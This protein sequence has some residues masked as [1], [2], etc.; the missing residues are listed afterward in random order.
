MNR[1]KELRLSAELTQKDVAKK[2]GLNQT[3]IG[4]YERGQL[5]P[6]LE[7][8]KELSLLFDCTIDYLVGHTDDFGNVVQKNAPLNP[9]V[10][11][12]LDIVQSLPREGQLQVLEY[13]Q[14]I[15][16]RVNPQK[17]KNIGV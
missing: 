13:A 16:S 11:E 3:A 8:L 10:N 4:K 6:S 12:L 17:K 7:T 2:L 15:N 9:I 5:E 14:Y 1:I